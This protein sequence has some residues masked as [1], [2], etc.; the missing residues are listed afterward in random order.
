M[1][2][3]MTAVRTADSRAVPTAGCSAE[4]RVGR[5]AVRTACY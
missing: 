4:R 2:V 5:T 1:R 3:E